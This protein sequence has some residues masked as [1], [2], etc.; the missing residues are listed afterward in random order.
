MA[1]GSQIDVRAASAL[2]RVVPMSLWP[3]AVRRRREQ[4]E[5]AAARAASLLSTLVERLDAIT[6]DGD[7]EPSLGAPEV[8]HTHRAPPWAAGSTDDREDEETDQDF[9]GVGDC[10]K[11]H[12]W[13]MEGG[14]EGD[15]EPDSEPSLGAALDAYGYA[16]Q[17]ETWRSDGA[18]LQMVGR[19][20]VDD[21]EHD[22]REEVSED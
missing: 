9:G 13:G 22:G 20:E 10:P 2:L 17:A 5:S 11:Q 21:A 19:V 8:L 16:D 15:G 7:F 14:P 6:P 18:R 4:L 3:E 12:S 1:D